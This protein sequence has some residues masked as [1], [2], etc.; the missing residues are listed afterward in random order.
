MEESASL[1]AETQE[2]W[3]RKA[4]F[5]DERFGDQ[6]NAFHQAVIAPATERLLALHPDE[7]V[8]LEEPVDPREPPAH[9]CFSWS[10]YK[11]IPPVL[12]ARMRLMLP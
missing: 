12:V 9:G 2:I 4:G 10:H 5:W 8:L 6:G 1:N 3:N 7:R 11:E